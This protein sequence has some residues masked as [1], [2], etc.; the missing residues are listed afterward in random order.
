[1]SDSVV[2]GTSWFDLQANKAASNLI[3]APQFTRVIHDVCNLI[4]TTLLH[5]CGPN[6]SFA[7]LIDPARPDTVPQFTT[8]GINILR[9]I[10]FFNPLERMIKHELAYLG[11]ATERAVGDGTTTAM[12]VGAEVLKELIR[13]RDSRP[14]FEKIRN[15][16]EATK[17]VIFPLLEQ[18]AVHYNDL[19][20]TTREEA[21]WYLAYLQAYASSHQDDALSKTVADVFA[22][23]PPEAWSGI[24][25]HRATYETKERITLIVDDAQFSCKAQVFDHVSLNAMGG[26]EYEMDDVCLFVPEEQLNAGDPISIKV[27]DAAAELAAQGRNVLIVTPA[28]LDMNTA[29]FLQRVVSPEFAIFHLSANNGLQFND[30]F[31]LRAVGGY[32]NTML[33]AATA[34]QKVVD[35]AT[36]YVVCKKVTYRN[37]QLQFYGLYEQ[38][39]TEEHPKCND[40]HFGLK[41]ALDQLSLIIGR[42]EN[43]PTPSAESQATLEQLRSL[44][45][46]MRYSKIRKIIVGGSSRE[47]AHCIDVIMDALLA[48]KNTLV[49]GCS[50]A[51]NK[52]LYCIMAGFHGLNKDREIS[53]KEHPLLDVVQGCVT[54]LQSMA[55]VVTSNAHYLENYEDDIAERAREDKNAV[56]D[57]L[58]VHRACLLRDIR[59]FIAS[60]GKTT[61]PVIQPANLEPKIFTLLGDSLLKYAWLNLIVASGCIDR[62]KK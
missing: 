46:R 9:A 50:P 10:E 31:G 41:S 14:N 28:G 45:N 1:M 32:A 13:S 21:I 23:T 49:H 15:E 57:R 62:S 55:S 29:S 56:E 35:A 59:V 20:S 51:L 2:T 60:K 17:K 25:F 40:D 19:H 33:T 12:I 11:S 44:R 47:H 22:Q 43:D 53:I 3:H 27:M 26:T 16:Y 38:G 18:A 37:K 24:T 58:T 34:E 61:P 4:K 54:A 8:D 36:N 30:Y 52:N 6:A 39:E 42:F 7:M 48:T 5:H